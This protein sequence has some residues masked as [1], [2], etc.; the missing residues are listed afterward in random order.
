M[1]I[2][3]PILWIFESALYALALTVIFMLIFGF[4]A[5]VLIGNSMSPTMWI[6]DVVVIKKV[7]EV[8]IKVGDVVT[9][10]KN[11][12]KVFTTHRVYE[13]V[14]GG[15]ITKGDA[16]ETTDEMISYSDIQGKVFIYIPKIGKVLN[17]FKNIYSL[18]AI[19]L[20]IFSIVFCI[21]FFKFDYEKKYFPE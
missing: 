11:S 5:I 7:E 10:G 3:R 14:E 4:R 12:S 17:L 13:I 8:D 6:N 9:F 19:V 2:Y 15:F 20:T 18:I 21:R 1:G 16:N